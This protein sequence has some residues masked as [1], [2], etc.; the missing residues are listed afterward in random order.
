LCICCSI[1]DTY[2][3]EKHFGTQLRKI[4]KSRP[5]PLIGLDVCTTS[6]NWVELALDNNSGLVLERCVTEPLQAGWMIAGHIEQFDEMS[7]ALRRLVKASASN[8]C[9]V[10]LAMPDSAVVTATIRLPSDLGATALLRQVEAEVERLSGRSVAVMSFD[11]SVQR[12]TQ[13]PGQ[14]AEV[15]VSIAAASQ[16]KVQDWLGLAESPGLKPVV[17]DV[18][19]EASMLAARRLIS[20]PPVTL[21]HPVVAL[22]QVG[23]EGASLHVTHQDEIVHASR[24]PVDDALHRDDKNALPA[25]IKTLADGLAS[26]LDALL[27]ASTFRKIDTVLLAADSPL[28]HGLQEAIKRRT[29]SDCVVVDPFSGMSLGQA[30]VGGVFQHEGR[31]GMLTACGLALRRFHG[32]C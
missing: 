28:L 26:D 7:A 15:E 22:F 24:K 27:S 19:A 18:R 4:F 6:L 2:R 5:R 29:F 21:G 13:A 10:A 1:D 9:D 25:M 20:A 16:E 12:R 23:S 8:T 11:Y 14:S 3:R 32:A 30:L 17:M 31:A